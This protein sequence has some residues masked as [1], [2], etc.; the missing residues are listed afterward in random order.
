MPFIVE[1]LGLDEPVLVALIPEHEGWVRD[2]LGTDAKEVG[3]V[4]ISRLGANPARIIPAWQ[5]FL[6]ASSGRQ[7]PARGVGEPIWPGR[8][9]DELLECQLHEALLN[10][11]IE[12]ES[13]SWIVCPYDATHLAPEVIEEAY[14]SHPVILEADTYSGSASYRGRDHVDSLIAGDLGGLDGTPRATEF[15]RENVNRLLAYVKLELYVA[16]LAANQAAELAA[17]VEG[18]ALSSLRR[19]ATHGDVRIWRL[20]DAVVCEVA[21]DIEVSD[22]LWGRRVPSAGNHDDLW[23]VNQLCDLVQMRSTPAGTTVRVHTWL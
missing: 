3:F 2:A 9:P 19:G 20:P 6:D 10:V 17:A 11:A 8:R 16:G 5:K 18:L 14:R 21:D 4:D 1:G 12:P 7:R 15:D 23:R 22:L 13:P